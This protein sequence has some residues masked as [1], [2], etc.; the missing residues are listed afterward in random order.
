MLINFSCPVC[1]SNEEKEL[2]N[3][4]NY[5]SVSKYFCPESRDKDR[6]RR[7]AVAIRRL[8]QQDTGYFLRCKV[9]SFG[10]GY[11]YVGGDEEF[12]EIVHEQFQYPAD[13]WE[14]DVTINKF[15]KKQSPEKIL[16]IGAGAGYFL[17][18]VNCSEKYAMEGSETIRSILRKKGIKVY[19]DEKRLI[20]ENGGS[21]N[22]ITMFQVLEHIA[23]FENMLNTSN[24]LLSFHGSLIIS[25]PDCDA[26][27]LQEKITGYP[28]IF[29]N[30]INKWTPGSL[31]IVLNKCGFK[32]DE[33]IYEPPSIRKFF[34]SIHLKISHNATKNGTLASVIYTIKTKKLRILA[35][36][37]YS[38]IE[39]PSLVYYYKKL[40]RA[41]SFLVKA[42]KFRNLN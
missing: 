4:Y 28:D 20:D 5:I 14:Y 18:K 35:L 36:L 19:I 34:D 39:L 3:K 27:I 24:K 32:I 10:F 15:F 42:K 6:N 37:F 31:E 17:D 41:G 9:C 22:Y 1:K 33:I 2:L 11:P 8:W 38:F 29:P 40:D 21:F 12:Y 7:F 26:M 13:R 16:D 30:H 23:E 25:V